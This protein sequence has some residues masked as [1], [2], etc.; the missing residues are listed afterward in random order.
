ISIVQKLILA[1]KRFRDGLADRLFSG[2]LREPRSSRSCWKSVALGDV[3]QERVETNRP[4]LELL[5][6]TADRGVI[7][8][9]EIDRKDSSNDDKRSYKRIAPGDIGYNTM[10]MWQGVSAL[11]ER[12]GI[13]SPAYT[14]CI[15]KPGIDGRFAAQLFKHPKTIHAFFR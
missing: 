9:G 3:F 12:E 10:R 1:K 4:D 15:P 11:S 14:V 13:V 6:I 7:P 8:R 5:S 2:N